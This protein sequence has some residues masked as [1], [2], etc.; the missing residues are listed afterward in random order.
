VNFSALAISASLVCACDPPQPLDRVEL[1]TGL[2]RASSSH[3]TDLGVT[4]GDAKLRAL[5]ALPIRNSAE[6]DATI[7]ALYDPQSPQFRNY[8]STEQWVAS[9]APAQE[10]VVAI[11]EWLEAGGLDVARVSRNRLLIEVQGT[12][13]DFDDTFF[14]EL[15]LL[16]KKDEDTYTTFGTE[17]PLFAPADIA[18]RIESVVVAD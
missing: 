9:Y 12:A 2:P 6:L 10:D 5:I 7:D 14:T 11:S 3:Y 4:S 8:L 1:V 17:Q 16:A 15:H 18:R 13:A